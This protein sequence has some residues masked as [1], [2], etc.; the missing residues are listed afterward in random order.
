VK[1]PDWRGLASYLRQRTA[2]DDLVVQSAADEAFTF[3]FEEYGAAGTTIRLPAN[4]FQSEAEIVDLA[5]A[6]LAN[7]ASVWVVTDPPLGWRNGSAALVWFNDYAQNLRTTRIDTLPIRQYAPWQIE[8]KAEQPLAQFG[9]A[10]ALMGATI[11]PLTEPT[12]E[13]MVWLEWLPL[14]TTEAPL[15]VFVHLIGATNPQT[16][17]PLWSQDDQFP[18]DGRLDST[19]WENILFRDVY[20]LPTTEIPPGEYRIIVGWYDPISNQ[21][22]MRDDAQGADHAEIG[23]VTLP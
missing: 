22:L 21:R 16:G 4:P 14:R 19:T 7:Y 12:G 15:K 10:A 8:L 23:T 11:A 20:A 5:E 1:S 6:A 17:T 13:R 2:P 3:Y 18:Q 9:E